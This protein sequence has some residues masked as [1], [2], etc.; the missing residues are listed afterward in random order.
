MANW[1][2]AGAYVIEV[3]FHEPKIY[4]LSDIVNKLRLRVLFTN[5][6]GKYDY[7]VSS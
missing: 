3:C 7:C 2:Y 6:N 1:Q 5:D 4:I